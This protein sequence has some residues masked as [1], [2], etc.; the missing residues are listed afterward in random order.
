M[1]SIK[2]SLIVSAVVV[3]L[4]TTTGGVDGYDV[5]MSSKLTYN[6][7]RTLRIAAEEVAEEEMADDSECEELE[8][9]ETDS[10]CESLDMAE[11]DN[12]KTNNANQPPSAVS[13]GNTGDSSQKQ[14]GETKDGGG[15]AKEKGVSGDD[16]EECDD[17]L[18][19]A[20]TDSECNSL[21]M[22]EDSKGA[23]SDPASAANNAGG[24]QNGG[25]AGGGQNGG[26][27]GG[28]T[29]TPPSNTG[30]NAPT[31]SPGNTNPGNVNENYNGM[32]S[33]ID[34]TAVQGEINPGTVVPQ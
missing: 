24:A 1:I 16:G 25:N 26:E 33:N 8:M 30:G 18:E 7:K 31:T 20:D 22:A 14:T 19:M 5:V 4:I 10:E 29:W 9:A 32:T 13:S 2:K 27:A 6:M 17:S 28:N 34:F 11:G 3:A 21:D 12:T 15:D 23:S